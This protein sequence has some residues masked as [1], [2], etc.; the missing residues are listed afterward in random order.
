LPDLETL[1]IPIWIRMSSAVNKVELHCFC[2]ASEISYGAVCYIRSVSVRGRISVQ[3][4]IGN[5]RVSH[6]KTI[7]I[8]CLELCACVV[9]VKLTQQVKEE[10]QSE[11]NRII[12]RTDS[13]SALQHIANVSRRFQRF[14][15]NRLNVIHEFPGV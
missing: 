11:I 8:P 2:D 6:L 14:V 1:R 9:G 3:F 7:T 10:I 15:A 5:S 12:F 4:V 13:T